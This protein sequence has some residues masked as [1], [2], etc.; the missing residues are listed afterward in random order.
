MAQ[1]QMQCAMRLV[2]GIIF[3]AKASMDPSTEPWKS[4]GL[5]RS[6][7]LMEELNAIERQTPDHPLVAVLKPIFEPSNDTLEKEAG[8]HN[9]RLQH[10]ALSQEQRETTLRSPLRNERTRRL[11]AL[12]P[13][14]FGSVKRQR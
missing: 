12:A 5:V 13:R 3:L 9:R 4:C 1:V 10:S 11:G 7:Y 14:A 2:Q 6:V 8:I